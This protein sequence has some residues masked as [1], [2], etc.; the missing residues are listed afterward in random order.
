MVKLTP[1]EPSDYLLDADD[2]LGFL[3]DMAEHATPEEFVQGLRIALR[4]KGMAALAAQLDAERLAVCHA[5]AAQEKPTFAAV[6]RMV[7]ALG[8]RLDLPQAA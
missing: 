2:V 4:S 3:E 7:Q 1:F 6:Y 8:L 5:V